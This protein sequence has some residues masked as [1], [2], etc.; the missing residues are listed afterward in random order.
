MINLM[1]VDDEERARIGIRTLIDWHQHDITIIAEAS[2]GAEALD[3]IRINHV[4]ILLTDIRMPEMDGLEL[5]EIVKQEFP[6]VKSVIMSGYNEF[7]YAKRALSLGASDY[8][9]KPSRRQ[10]ILKTVLNLTTEI[11]QERQ[12]ARNFEELKEGFRESLPLLKEKTLSRLVFSDEPPYEK[13]LA[14]LQINGICFPHNYFGVLIIQI[15][16]FHALQKQF[17]Q[18]DVELFKYALKNI[19][20]ETLLISNLCVAFEHHDDIII[21]IN[22]EMPMDTKVLIPYAAKIQQ[23][24]KN[25]LKFSISIGIGHMDSSLQYLKNSYMSASNALDAKYFLGPGKIVDFNDSVD[26]ELLDSSYP[27][28]MENSVLHAIIHGDSVKISESISLFQI[29]LKTESASKDDALKYSLALFFALYRLCIEKDINVNEIFGLNLQEIVQNLSKSTIESVYKELLDTANKISNQLQT[30]KNNNKLFMSILSY[31]EQNYFKE[32]SREIVAN[33]VYITPGYLS[34]LFKQQMK[35]SFLDYL[36]KIRIEH[37]CVL[38]KDNSRRIGDIALKVG[39]N[40]EKYFFQVFKKYTGMTP[41][42][43]RN[44]IKD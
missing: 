7:T 21:L 28:S 43:Y 34:L 42:Q 8:L 40:D 31:I 20:E 6:H 1:I 26:H 11:E 24:V 17:G 30:K 36:H 22:S 14:N 9:L 33:E 29:A 38:L 4:D 15:D 41:N 37:A 5:I 27:L 39:Y 10:E 16:N 23:N 18:F 35:T 12:Q 13:L 3:L 32:I 44:N 19:S 2:D 25:F